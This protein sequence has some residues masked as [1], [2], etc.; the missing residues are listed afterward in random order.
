[1]WAN[2]NGVWIRPAT[3]RRLASFQA[4]SMLLKKAGLSVALAV[5]ANP[6][7]VAIGRRRTHPRVQA[8]VDNRVNGFE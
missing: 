2:N 3:S 4:G 7:T 6:E 8:L 5:P 1:M